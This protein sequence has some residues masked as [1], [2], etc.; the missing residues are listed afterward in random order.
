[1]EGDFISNVPTTPGSWTSFSPRRG[2]R[3]LR[4]EGQE[5][6]EGIILS[7]G[8]KETDGGGEDGAGRK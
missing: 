6:H 5:I 8:V 7:H 2:M 1:M 4:R 3:G